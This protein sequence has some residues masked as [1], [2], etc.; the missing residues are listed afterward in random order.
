MRLGAAL[1]IVGIVAK[2]SVLR[3]YLWFNSSMVARSRVAAPLV[4]KRNWGSGRG[5]ERSGNPEALAGFPS[6]IEEGAP[7]EFSS[8]RLLSLSASPANTDCYRACFR[9]HACKVTIAHP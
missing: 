2:A 1:N 4:R 9:S 5:G 6:E 8:E 7:W 3:P